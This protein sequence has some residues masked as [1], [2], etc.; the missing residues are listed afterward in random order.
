MIYLLS[1]LDAG[2]DLGPL[3][4]SA[5][6]KNIIAGLM[7][8]ELITKDIKITLLG[9]SV[10]D[11]TKTTEGVTL[12]K[13]KNPVESFDVWWK[14]YPGTDGFKH[15]SKTFPLTRNLRGNKSKALLYWNKIIN[16]GE[17][18]AHEIIE[19]TKFD[20]LQRK[21]MSVKKG[22]NQLTF[23]QNSATYLFQYTYEAFVELI[24]D[25][26]TIEKGPTK[27]REIDI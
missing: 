22:K 12:A 10:L 4:Q 1:L 5:R 14:I 11:F 24:K 8:K 17:Y 9:K 27:G 7:R 3:G 20:V 23:M 16:K 25:G 2:F 15:R 13:K 18:T 21:E 26:T 6:I 19:A